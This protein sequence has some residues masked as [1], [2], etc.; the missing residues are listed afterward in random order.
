M[1]TIVDT[2]KFSRMSA[3][4]RCVL[5]LSRHVLQQ[6]KNRCFSQVSGLNEVVIV[7]AARTPI[8]SFLSKF[9]SVPA[10]ELGATSIRAAVSR[11]GIEAGLVDE[12]YMG[13][14]IQ[15]GGG[16]APARQAALFA[17]L[18]QN[19]P[20][21][22]VNKVCASG[23]KSMS[24]VPYY[25][26]RGATPY[27]GISMLDGITYDGLTDVYNKF[28][29]GNCGENTAQKYGITREQQDEYAV[30]SYTRSQTAAQHGV[31]AS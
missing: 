3:S 11:A 12:V 21:T 8:A 19:T 29:M 26:R 18:D 13:Q 4:L 16:Q 5:P 31:F 23:M 20:C 7:S 2:S 25:Q 22:T 14:V 9:N 30:Q 10:T 28:H 27:G 17:G 6:C 15:A 24:Q 1:G